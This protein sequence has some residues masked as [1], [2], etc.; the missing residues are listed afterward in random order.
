MKP[1]EYLEL[2]ERYR[3]VLET[4]T[5]TFTRHYLET[6]ERS[7]RTLAASGQALLKSGKIVDALGKL[8]DS[9][10]AK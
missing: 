10:K 3:E 2:A 4:A 1:E 5:D 7:Y 9:E 6:M 8:S